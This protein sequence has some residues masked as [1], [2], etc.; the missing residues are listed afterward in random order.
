MQHQQTGLPSMHIKNKDQSATVCA[1]KRI[2]LSGKY[3]REK[4]MI[5][6]LNLK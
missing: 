1:T 2:M 5:D 6:M 3:I 4:R